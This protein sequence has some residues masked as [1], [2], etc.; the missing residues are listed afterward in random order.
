MDR[1]VR[2]GQD[3]FRYVSGNWAEDTPIPADRSSYGN[4]A[5]LR[6]LS[7]A[8]S[9]THLDVYKRQGP[10]SDPVWL[11]FSGIDPSLFFDDNGAAW[12]VNNDIPQGL[13]LIH[14]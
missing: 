7:E 1:S 2:P 5:V 9:Y 14:I 11:G 8:V 4:F 3:F 6:D 10:W 13:S 12:M